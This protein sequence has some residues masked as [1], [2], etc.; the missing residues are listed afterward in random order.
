MRALWS[1]ELCAVHDGTIPSFETSRARLDDLAEFRTLFQPE[2][3]NLRKLARVVA[4]GVGGAVLL[5]PVAL[6]AAPGMAAALGAWG[7]LGAAATGTAIET[8]SGAALTSASLAA[9]GAGLGVAGGTAVVTAAG[10]ALGAHHGARVSQAYTGPIE[11][12]AITK[13]RSGHGPAVVVIDGFLTQRARGGRD[14]EPGLA[15]R[16]GDNPLYHVAWESKRLHDLASAALTGAAKSSILKATA[17]RLAGGH[18]RKQPLALGAISLVAGLAMNP[19]HTAVARASMTGGLLAELLL[20][21]KHPA[22]FI[23][24]G[25]SLG[26][27]VIYSA[28][29]AL[30]NV[31]RQIVRDVY[32]LG[33]AASRG[34]AG[35][36]DTALSAVRGRTFNVWSKRD[37]ILSRLYPVAMGFTEKPIGVAPLEICSPAL[38]NVDVSHLVSGHTDYK[39]KL[40]IVLRAVEATA[41]STEVPA[42]EPVLPAV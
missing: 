12:F 35:S 30:A 17:R 26:A 36:W 42:A 19:W 39:R 18:D 5:A 2:K 34:K 7:W 27:R 3:R 6:V 24:V 10:A 20:R 9:L 37:A 15:E 22:G 14:W 11:G 29:Q 41:A 13:L 4:G 23:L 32:L 38:V 8:L 1:D 21:T 40:A 28:L 33:G 25:H 16:F 31:D